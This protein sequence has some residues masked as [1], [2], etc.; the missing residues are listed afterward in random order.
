M[1]LIIPSPDTNQ[2]VFLVGANA[3]DSQL[4]QKAMASPGD[5]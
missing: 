4:K 1:L 2:E 3:L 5:G